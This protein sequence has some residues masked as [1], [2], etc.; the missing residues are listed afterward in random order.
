[1]QDLDKLRKVLCRELENIDTN[2]LTVNKLE[3]IDKITHSIKSIDTINAMEGTHDSYGAS[4]DRYQMDREP[5]YSYRRGRDSMGR[6]SRAGE[7]EELK[8]HL[9]DMMNSASGQERH[10]IERWLKEL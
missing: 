8:M 7:N 2:N 6:Y 3:M 4:Y 5:G 1:M 9:E 10:L